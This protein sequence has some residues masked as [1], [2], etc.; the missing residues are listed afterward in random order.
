M[1]CTFAWVAALLLLPL[2]ILWRLS[3]SPQQNVKRLRAAGNTYKSIAATLNVS[4]T[5]A[6]RWALA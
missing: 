3:L 1:T 2:I 5:T 4:P 6:R